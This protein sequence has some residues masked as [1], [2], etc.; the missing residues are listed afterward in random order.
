VL[1]DV[2]IDLHQF[3]SI[4]LPV[5]GRD[6]DLLSLGEGVASPPLSQEEKDAELETDIPTDAEERQEVFRPRVADLKDKILLSLFLYSGMVKNMELIT[7]LEKRRHLEVLWHGWA[8]M[9]I[10][11][12]RF[13]PRLAKERRVRINGALYEVQAPQ[14]MSDTTLLRQMMIYLPHVH[15]RMISSTLGTEKLERQLTEPTLSEGPDPKIFDF[16]R[17]DLPLIFSSTWS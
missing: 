4:H 10:A 13:A 12:L 17:T 1:D 6:D 9:L 5:E 15:V 3:D 14:G 7:D 8:V 16:F 11:A 2:E